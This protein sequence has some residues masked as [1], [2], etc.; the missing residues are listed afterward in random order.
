MTTISVAPDSPPELSGSKSS[1][2]SSF[3]SSSQNSGPDDILADISNFEDIGLE[4]RYIDP[5]HFP[6]DKSA[7]RSNRRLVPTGIRSR[8]APMATTTRDLTVSANRKNSPKLQGH[9]QVTE[10]SQSLALPRSRSASR[11]VISSFSSPSLHLHPSPRQRSRSPSPGT[12]P[13]ALS[14]RN[15]TPLPPRPRLPTSRSFTHSTAQQRHRKT[16]EELEDEYHDSDEELPEGATLWNVPISPRPPHERHGGRRPSPDRR[17]PGPRPIPLS[18]STSA[19]PLS[20]PPTTSPPTSARLKS[21]KLPRASSLGPPRTQPVPRSPRIN[22]WNLVMSELS[23]E[24]KI[25]TEALEFHADAAIQKREERLQSGKSSTRSRSEDGKRASNG[26]IQLPP[27][28]KSNIMIDPLPIS[29]E[30]EKVL[31]RTRPSW[32]PPKDPR[33]E[34]KHLLEY[35]RMMELSREADKRKA[36]EAASALCKK[37]DT[38]KMLQ[39][40]WDDYVFPDWDRVISEH[41]TRELWWRGIT[42]RSR[43]AVWQRALGNELA[44]TEETYVKA[45][46]RAKD[47][48]ITID[49]NANDTNERMK[50]WFAAIRRDASTVFPDLHLFGEDGPLRENLIN[51]LDAYSMYRSDVG[52]LYGIH[53]IAALLLLNLP[54]PAA[55]FQ[56]LANA[57]NKPLPL[58]FLTADPG[59]TSRAYS[60]ASTTL[61]LKYPRVSN[62]LY[63]NMYLSDEQIWGPMFQTLVTNGLD[64]ERLSRVWDCWV[65]EG[66]RIIIRAAVTIV[67]CLETTILNILP[68]DEGQRTCIRLLGWGS[69]HVERAG[70]VN[71]VELNHAEV[72]GNGD[73]GNGNNSVGNELGGYWILNNAGDEDAFMGMVRV[74]QRK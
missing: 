5:R 50:E 33:E 38:R 68:D 10:V 48:Q 3:R 24:A 74:A 6:Q 58:A 71:S 27:L 65:F 29:K 11:R 7:L 19:P 49:D 43:G 8:T 57:L 9:V 55:A 47:I 62:H 32:L 70:R 72:D 60:L 45:L 36:A 25:L 4:D 37:D 18:H 17:S 54:T 28:Q 59:A 66:D 13:T 20:A 61:R 42:P 52:Y 51:V 34:R 30:K 31:S 46:E 22:S 40:I 56:T 67:G 39:R 69:K 23:E 16:V 63:E 64:L 26:M 53:T 73:G 41:R 44:L 1:K 2:S 21:H 12:Q 14:S 35:K 15:S